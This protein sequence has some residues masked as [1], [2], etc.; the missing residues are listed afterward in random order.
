MARDLVAHHSSPRR[1]RNI[2]AQ[3]N[4]LGTSASAR[5]SCPVGAKQALFHPYRVELHLYMHATH[6]V[7]LG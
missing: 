4:A 2:T 5:I 7:A 6:G 3:G 1:G